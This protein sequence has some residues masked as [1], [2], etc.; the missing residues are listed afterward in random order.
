MK[1]Y[2]IFRVHGNIRFFRG[3]LKKAGAWTVCRLK[4]GLGEK[5][6]G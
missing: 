5:E 4:E 1:N 6:G 2:N 3:A